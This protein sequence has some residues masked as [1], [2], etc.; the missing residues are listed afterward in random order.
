MPKIRWDENDPSRSSTGISRDNLGDH[1]QGI[2]QGYHYGSLTRGLV[3]YW[4]FDDDSDTTTAIDSALNNDGSFNGTPSYVSGYINQALSLNGTDEY[5]NIGNPLT[6][7]DGSGFTISGWFYFDNLTSDHGLVS[8]WDGSGNHGYLLRY[9]NSN[10]T[11]D[12]YIQQN[13][14]TSVSTSIG[15]SNFSSSSWTH[16]TAVGDG[17]SG[18]IRLYLNGDS[19]VSTN[20]FDGT[21]DN[22]TIDAA[23]GLYQAGSF[24]LTGDVDEVRIYDRVLSEPEISALYNLTAPSKVYTEDTLL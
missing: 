1:T 10:S 20:T 24:Y 16:F 2:Q 6:Q 15:D 13:N 19:V 3:G 12:F 17:K 23:I 4:R 5:V 18:E 21:Y 7:Q 14:D 9:L 22:T 8:Q 11:M